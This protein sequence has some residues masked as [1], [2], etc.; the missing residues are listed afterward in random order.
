M[1]HGELAHWEQTYQKISGVLTEARHTAWRSINTTMLTAYWE[2]GRV[3]VE[4][5]QQGKKKA[6]YGENLIK[7]LSERLSKEFGKGFS[8]SNLKDMRLFYLRYPKSQAVPSFLS[9][10]HLRSLL[11]VEKPEARAFYEKEAVASRWSTREL[12]RQIYSSLFER[13]AL[14]RDK[15]GVLALTQKGHELLSPADLIKDPYVLEFTGIPESTKLLESTLE[16]ALIA[17]MQ[18]F[19]LELGKGF[20]FVGRQQRIKIGEKHFYIDLVFYNRFTKSFV[21]FDIK[22]GELTHQD[23]GQMQMYVNYYTREITTSEENP[24]IGVILCAEKDKTVVQYTL[25]ENNQQ[26][27]VSKY[28]LY[29]PTE[30]ELVRE[31]ERE[32]AALEPLIA[33]ET[34]GN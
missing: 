29:L 33:K 3:I 6:G 9:W 7:S 2:V 24:P 4:G 20:S 34:T 18:A 8:I 1:N 11:R 16:Q 31:L 10:T 21:L 23:I 17:R 15:A 22:T 5:E 25:P 14:S 26:I 28:K 19:L 32:Q 27:F 30:E 13:L 12:D